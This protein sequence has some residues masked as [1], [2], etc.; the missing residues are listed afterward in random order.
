MY[1]Y[2]RRRKVAAQVAEEL[3][4]ATYATPPTEER[5]KKEK[6][7]KSTTLCLCCETPLLTEHEQKAIS[8]LHR[9]TERHAEHEQEAIAKL[10]ILPGIL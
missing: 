6:G 1:L 5:R 2:P 10:H 8:T 3:K 7:K 4:T 9:A